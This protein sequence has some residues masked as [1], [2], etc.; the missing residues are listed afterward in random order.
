MFVTGAT[1]PA[2]HNE[3]W[4]ACSSDLIVVLDGA[5][6]RT[7]TGCV[8][9]PAWYARKLGAAIISR[10]ASRSVVLPQV[11]ANA[12]GDVAQL[13]ASTC[14]LS[15]PA[16]PSAAVA[17]VRIEQDVIRYLVLG[18]ITIIADVKG[19]IQAVSDDR[20]S[21]TA[22]QERQAADR[23]PIGTPEKDAAMRRMKEVELAA[24]N[25]D[26]GYWI[27]GS[28]SGAVDHAVVGEWKTQDLGR[29][30]VLS[31]GAARLVNT[32]GRATW[33]SVLDILSHNGPER[34]IELVR[35]A[36]DA[37]SNGIQ[38]PRNKKSDDATVVYAIPAPTIRTER[39]MPSVEA[40]Q[41]ALSNMF[42]PSGL[43]GAE[44]I[45]PAWLTE[46]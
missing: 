7:E 1:H 34:L 41:A 33:V 44:P 5:T 14:D 6:V 19:D 21:L 16:A 35:L 2:G 28:D 27:A 30:A 37:D 43:M 4:L 23:F 13:H 46:H 22:L 38:Y 29:L 39:R 25:K 18:D 17:V 8:H 12:I 26:G 42:R 10:A 31:D 40:R 3:D 20:V 32:F 24:K 9:G 15:D 36:E 45:D 11:L